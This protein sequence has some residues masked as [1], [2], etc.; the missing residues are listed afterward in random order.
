MVMKKWI[1]FLL[2]LTMLLSCVALTA[3]NEQETDEPDTEETESISDG[4][5]TATEKD[6]FFSSGMTVILVSLSCALD[7]DTYD[8]ET[9]VGEGGT[10]TV[11]SG[12]G[13]QLAD[14]NVKLKVGINEFQVLYVKGYAKRAY[15]IR[16]AR[17]DT[18]RVILNTNGGSYIAPLSV[19]DGEVLD[20]DQYTPTRGSGYTFAGWYK[21]GKRVTG[22]QV[23]ISDTTF[24]AQWTAPQTPVKTNT[25][26]YT[27]YTTSSAA[28]NIVWKDYDNA[29]KLRPTEVYC[30]LQG[31]DTKPREV[32]T[33]RVT[34]DSAEFV[35]AGPEGAKI[36]QGEGVWTVKI[37]GLDKD[38]T[39]V[40]DDLQND[41]YTSKQNGTAV[42]NTYVEYSPTYD[43][44]AWLMTANGRLYDHAGNLVTLRGVVAY[45][46]GWGSFDENVSRANLTRMKQEG[47]NCIRV[48]VFVESSSDIGYYSSNGV[49]STGEQRAKLLKQIKTAIDNASALGMYCIVD[50]GILGSIAMTPAVNACAK[51]LFST[52]ATEYKNNPFAIYEICNEPVAD[53][54]GSTVVPYAEDVIAAIRQH[55][56]ALV[57]LAPDAAASNLSEYANPGDD[58]IDKPISS[59]LS[60]NVAYTFHCYAASHKYSGSGTVYGWKIK[61][62]VDAGLTLIW[63]EF[64]PAVAT[65]GSTSLTVDLDEANKFL[66]FILENDQ[67]FMM[68]RFLSGSS[69]KD[70]GQ[71]LFAPNYTKQINSGS[72]TYEMLSESGKWFF[73]NTLMSTG[74]IKHATF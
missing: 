67:S 68:F 27:T 53:S 29:F 26:D 30:T 2:V 37:T 1:S 15:R 12:S 59:A 51:E 33:V 49:V 13:E 64:S 54:W 5:T 34:R 23:V 61:D 42:V 48:T 32:Y 52:L 55:S 46:V 4:E 9:V 21:D 40:Q 14:P 28:L 25:Q 11:V 47:I 70:S 43:D 38:Y 18:Y 10:L 63:T 45:N 62:A 35:G 22:E 44:T 58:P 56:D 50:W 60:H 6:D 17:R 20:L 69:S 41:N 24:V 36:A 74:F 8:L 57:I 31:S 73:F 7:K 16:I 71:Y 72:W 39:F 66:N 19:F 65:M 3:C